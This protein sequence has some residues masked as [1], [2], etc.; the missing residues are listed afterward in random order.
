M[1]R[2]WP[3]LLFWR[4]LNPLIRPLAGLAPWWVLVETTG[5]KTGKRRR[6]P[7]AVGRRRDDA[8][9]V[10]AVHGRKSGW[11]RNAEDADTVRYKHRLRW[12]TATTHTHEWDEELVRSMTAYARSGARAVGDAP[13]VVELRPVDDH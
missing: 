6:T 7:L 5:R 8:M 13:L 11:V 4:I 2:G 1:R 9:W 3:V 10:I 12:R